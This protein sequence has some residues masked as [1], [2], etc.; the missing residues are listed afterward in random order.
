MPLPQKYRLNILCI[1]DDFTKK[2]LALEPYVNLNFAHPKHQPFFF[3]KYDFLLVESTWLGNQSLWR[4]KV[5]TYPEYPERNNHQLAKL[6]SWAKNHNIPT[7]FWNKE[8]PFHF[9]QFINSAELFDYIFTTDANLIKHYQKRCPRSQIAALPF[10][11]QPRIH[12]PAPFEQIQTRSSIFIGSYMKHMHHERRHWQDLCFNAA[13][14]FGLTIVDRHTKLAQKDSSY[15]FP[16][17][18]NIIYK[19]AVDYKKTTRLNHAFQQSINVN[20]I[21]NSPTMFSRR[22]IEIMA[23]NRLVISNPSTSID[24]LFSDLCET[25]ETPEQAN[26]LFEQ[27]QYGYSSMQMEKIN[28]A[29]DHVYQN[30]TVRSWLQNILTSCKIDHPYTLLPLADYSFNI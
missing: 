2:T 27:L 22:L 18:N 30:Y 15:Q 1:L 26:A 19:E 25:I 16:K 11:F 14:P 20:T 10:P 6:V 23:C 8:D 5:A 24:H 28:A 3:K 12:Y 7:I 17:I 13:A 21:T 9:E 29:R 4:H